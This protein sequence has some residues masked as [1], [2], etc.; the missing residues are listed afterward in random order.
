MIVYG[1]H[2]TTQQEQ[3]KVSLLTNESYLTLYS[4]LLQKH[5]TLNHKFPISEVI[6]VTDFGEAFFMIK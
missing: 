6:S 2:H 5:L 4:H 3:H 1:S